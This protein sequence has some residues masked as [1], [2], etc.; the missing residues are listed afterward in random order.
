MLTPALVWSEPSFGEQTLVTGCGRWSW[1]YCGMRGEGF[2]SCT[3]L[4]HHFI[5]RLLPW[6]HL[7]GCHLSRRGSLLSCSTHFPSMCWG[8]PSV[9]K[10]RASG[11]QEG[12]AGSNPTWAGFPGETMC[13]VTRSALPKCPLAVGIICSLLALTTVYLWGCLLAW[14]V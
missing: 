10:P 9:K 1:D 11:L 6:D 7:Q 4:S 13:L 3:D 12:P 5:P 2:S 14:N 8:E